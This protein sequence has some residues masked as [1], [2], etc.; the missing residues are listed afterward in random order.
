MA[1]NG[2]GTYSLANTA[3]ADG[4]DVT[5]ALWNSQFNDLATAM[6]GSV[7]RDGQAGMSGNLAMGSNKL[8]GLGN[9]S[10]RTDSVALGQLQDSTVTWCGTAG[11]TANALTLSPSPAIAAYAAGQVFRFKAGASPNT[12]ATTVAVSGLTATAV[13]NNGAALAGGEIEASKWYEILYDGAAF[14]LQKYIVGAFIDTSPVVQGSADGTK[15]LRFEVDGF[16][17]ATTRV[18]TAPNYDGTIATLGGTETLTAKTLTSP[19]I[20]TTVTG[21]AVASQAQMET[22]TATNVLVTPGRQAYHPSSPKAWVY[23]TVSGTTVTV[24]TSYNVTGVVRNATGDYTVTWTTAFSSANYA[25]FVCHNADRATIGTTPTVA[26]GT[27][28]FK[29]IRASDNSDQDPTIV[30]VM[31][32]G[33]Q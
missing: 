2:S 27:L 22:G 8:T 30:S 18:L 16:T 21:T 5:A 17:T 20:D 12:T 19:V 11:G 24:Q 9:G 15:K 14:Q 28:R 10:A 1:R 31:A 23:F 33:D 3:V 29:T 13:Q 7:P 6:T 25:W 32:F 4:N 26:A